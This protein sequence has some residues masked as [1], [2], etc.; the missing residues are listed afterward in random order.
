MKARRSAAHRESH[1]SPEAGPS[2]TVH[3]LVNGS[4]RV[5]DKDKDGEENFDEQIP[6]I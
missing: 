3:L 2:V 4:S 1:Q 6:M 5:K